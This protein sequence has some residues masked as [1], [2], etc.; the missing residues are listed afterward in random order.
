[1]GVA[2]SNPVFP[3]YEEKHQISRFDASLFIKCYITIVQSLIKK[4]KGPFQK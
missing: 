2:G 3:I 4:L 1:V